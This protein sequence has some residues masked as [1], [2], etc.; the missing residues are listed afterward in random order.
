MTWRCRRAS[1][2]RWVWWGRRWGWCLGRS[3]EG[4]RGWLL[5]LLL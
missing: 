3:R 4:K 2:R 1:L 5:L